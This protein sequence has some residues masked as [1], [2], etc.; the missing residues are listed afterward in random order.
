MDLQPKRRKVII[1]DDDDDDSNNNNNNEEP[2]DLNDESVGSNPDDKMDD[3]GS[4][5]EGEDLMENWM[6]DYAPAPELDFYDPTLLT[7]EV[8]VESFAEQMRYRRA[9]E[10]E[11][12]AEDE[13]RRRQEEE[14]EDNLEGLN[15]RENAEILADDDDDDDDEDEEGGA[16]TRSL[17]LEA[18]ECPLHEWISEERT[19]QEVK[20]RFRKF[21]LKYYV[22]IDDVTQY[23]KR[24]GTEQG[25]PPGLKKLPPIYPP[26]IRY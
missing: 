22:S 13:R 17:N 24:F 1:N 21:L 12:D 20:K 4:E 23:E 8:V 16:V 9:A 19:R 2:N 15:E 5:E 7:D 26:K 18:F 6:A 11:L 14:A 3:E 10:E 25:L